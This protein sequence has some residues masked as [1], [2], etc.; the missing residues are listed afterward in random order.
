MSSRTNGKAWLKGN[1]SCSCHLPLR[2][3][4]HNT[5]LFAIVGKTQEKS[6]VPRTMGITP[7][8]SY[9]CSDSNTAYMVG[10]VGCDSLE[11][12]STP[13]QCIRCTHLGPGAVLPD[14]VALVSIFTVF[15]TWRQLRKE[16][17][18]KRRKGV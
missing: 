10:W 6:W 4:P 5:S 18:L 2:S 3:S 1:Y 12:T 8:F 11:K 14:D 16:L 7:I 15:I 13:R 9:G 17:V